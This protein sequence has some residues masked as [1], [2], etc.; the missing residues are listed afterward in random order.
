MTITQA[1]RVIRSMGLRAVY[2]VTACEFR[3]APSGVKWHETAQE[4]EEAV[5]LARLLVRS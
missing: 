1:I 3:F 5:A 2:S 4:P